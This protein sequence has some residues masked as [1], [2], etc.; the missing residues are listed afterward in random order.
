MSKKIIKRRCRYCGQD[1]S[2]HDFARSFRRNAN[3]RCKDCAKELYRANSPEHQDKWAYI[4]EYSWTDWF[5]NF[6]EPL[7]IIPEEYGP[8]TKGEYYSEV[9]Q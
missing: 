6:V 1:K 9:E 7:P 5:N 4:D 2:I 8:W 3:K